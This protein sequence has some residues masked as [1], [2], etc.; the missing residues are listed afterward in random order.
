MRHQFL[1]SIIIL[2][3]AIFT[4]ALFSGCLTDDHGHTHQ[5]K[6][7]LFVAHEGS[8]TSYDIATGEQQ[9]GEI[10]DVSGPTD[11]QSLSNGTLLVN[12]TNRNEVLVVNG[13]S[14]VQ[15]K[16]IPSALSGSQ[17]VRPVHS[18]I[19]PKYDGKQY[20]M[21]LNDGPSTGNT[22]AANSALFID[23]S[24]PSDTASIKVVGEVGIGV[25]HHKACFSKSR[26]R[27]VIT[28]IN[29]AAKVLGVYDYSNPA[30]I[31]EVAAWS[32]DDLGIQGSAAPHGC[33]TSALNGKGYCNATGTGDII[34]VDIDANP[35]T[36]RLLKTSGSGGGYTKGKGRYVYSLQS[37]PREGHT[38]L[39]GAVCQ[40]GQIVVID[41][42]VDSVVKEVAVKYTGPNCT[43]SILG[44]PEATAGPGHIKIAGNKLYVQLASGFTDPTGSAAKHLVLDITDLANP[45]QI[46]SLDIGK[47]RSHHGECLSG[48]DK[49]FFVANNLDGTVTQID[50]AAG[51]VTKALTVRANPRTLATWHEH[52]GPSH[53][54]GPLE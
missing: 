12:L 1:F 21:A 20:W 52:D 7:L 19:S 35:P 24:T 2:V 11:I 51:K 29:D 32:A 44:K 8:I 16:R 23:L 45:I 27:V 9:A 30:A 34:S 5:H 22:A 14:M 10:V 43:E 53:H 36:A 6:H 28:N 13:K 48:D 3:P 54:Y 25:G 39:P 31:T 50:A 26:H 4:T 46:A 18:Y 47:S 41:A 17:A 33:A 42:Q 40:V 38:T 37:T 15:I 49:Y